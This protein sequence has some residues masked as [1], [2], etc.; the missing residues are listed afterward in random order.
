M[1]DFFRSFNEGRFNDVGGLLSPA[2]ESYSL[3]LNEHFV[4]FT[5]S[6]AIAHLRE[7]QTAGDRFTFVGVKVQELTGWDGATHFGEINVA[8]LRN[9]AV[10]RLAGKGSTFC[11]GP[12]AGIKVLALGLAP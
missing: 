4:A 2:F 5:R 12:L 7:R 6:D 8:L 10:I 9:G 3:T 11:R 1:R